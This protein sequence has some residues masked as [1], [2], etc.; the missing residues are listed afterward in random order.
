V[1]ISNLRSQINSK[2]KLTSDLYWLSSCGKPLHDFVPFKEVTGVVIISGN[3]TRGVESC[4]RGCKNEVHV[5]TH[6][7]DSMIGQYEIKCHPRDF[8]GD[9]EKC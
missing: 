5:G 7:Y 3:L 1:I 9:M 4:L 6:K 2:F 8:T